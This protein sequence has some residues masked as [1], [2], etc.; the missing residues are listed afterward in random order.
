MADTTLT[1]PEKHVSYVA[2]KALVQVGYSGEEFDRACEAK[3]LDK[4]REL[5]VITSGAFSM[6]DQLSA[7]TRGDATVTAPS[8]AVQAVMATVHDWTESDI[9]L[10]GK[11]PATLRAIADRLEWLE[12]VAEFRKPAEAVA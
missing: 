10:E 11:E 8:E 3:D 9:E 12:S 7:H 5:L 4:V 6:F 2:E 1:I